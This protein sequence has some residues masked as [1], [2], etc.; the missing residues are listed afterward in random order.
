MKEKDEPRKPLVAASALDWSRAARSPLLS[1]P[2]DVVVGS[3]LVYGEAG[4]RDLATC[5]AALLLRSSSSSS[6]GDGDGDDD[7]A[8]KR[9]KAFG[10]RDGSAADSKGVEGRLA[11]VCFLAQTCGRWGGYGYD[12]ALYESLRCAG[13]RATP[14]GGETPRDEDAARQHVCVFSVEPAGGG[15]RGGGASE[16]EDEAHHPLLRARRL[17][18]AA[19]AAAEAGMSEDDRAAAEAQRAMERLEAFP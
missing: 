14:V 19:E 13:L 4:A 1:E 12:A 11:P 10:S 15:G 9:E 16:A 6:D 17:R 18:A 3:D 5:L 8:E 2:W 7:D